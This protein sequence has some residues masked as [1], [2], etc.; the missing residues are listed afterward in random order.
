MCEVFVKVADAIVVGEW[1][2]E[3]KEKDA[4]ALARVV[5]PTAFVVTPADELFPNPVA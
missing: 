1:R 5:L 4:F 3:L 2:F